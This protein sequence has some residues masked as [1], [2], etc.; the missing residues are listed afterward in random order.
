MKKLVVILLFLIL[1][2]NLSALRV[3][4]AK[5]EINFKSNL[6]KDFIYT[7]N[8]LNPNTHFDLYAK[9]DLVQYVTLDKESLTGGGSFIA[10]LKLPEEI[11]IPGK[12]II[13]I[14]IREKVDEEL[15]EAPVGTAVAIQSVIIINVPYPGKYVETQ[16]SANDANIGE[17]V[18]FKLFIQSRGD[19]DVTVSPRIDVFSDKGDMINSISFNDRNLGKDEKLELQKTLNTA[20]F[21]S[22]TYYAIASVNYGDKISEKN[23]SFRIGELSLKILNT[24]KLIK[25]GG[26]RKFT[27]QVESSWNNK[28]EGAYAKIVIYNKSGELANFKTVP[29]ELEAWEKKDIIGFFDASDFEPG[30]YSDIVTLFYFGGSAGKSSVKFDSV[31]F[32]KERIINPYMILSLV[33]G[34]LLIIN[35]FLLIKNERKKK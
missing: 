29:I 23:V 35:V 9:G 30:N 6:E 1:I 27:V 12:H 17:P 4:P 16:F 8:H 15:L 28:I 5:T 22:G 25:V 26:I 31:R 14:G 33:L 7:V 19:E 11:E 20:N 18:I 3:I 24:S 10:H 21:N 2:Q 13:Y 34:I 32:I